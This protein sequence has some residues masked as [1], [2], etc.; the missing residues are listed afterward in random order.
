MPKEE[1]ETSELEEEI[2][3]EIEKSSVHEISKDFTQESGGELTEDENKLKEFITQSFSSSNFSPSLEKI[4]DVPQQIEVEQEFSQKTESKPQQKMYVTV[5]QEEKRLY[6]SRANSM[7]PPVLKP[8]RMATQ[9]ANF[10]DP[11][12]GRNIPTQDDLRP[13]KIR[14]QS[15]QTK[16]RLPFEREAN[17]K[18]KEVKL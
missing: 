1:E 13:Q 11:L 12:A 9:R 8:N 3:K 14:T 6:E 2:V 16:Q 5:S 17:D 18:Y 7:E 15:H 4:Q 10:I